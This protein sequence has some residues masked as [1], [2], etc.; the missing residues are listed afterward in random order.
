MRILKKLIIVGMCIVLSLSAL[1]GCSKKPSGNE[2][3]SRTVVDMKG[4]TVKLPGTIKSYCVLYSSAVPMCAMVD[5]NLEHM[6][7][8]P[9]SNYFEY[10]YGE[11]FKTVDN[12]AV[13]VDKKKVT[14][15][16]IIESGAQVVFWNRAAHEDLVASLE[17]VGIAC[18]NVQVKDSNDLI[19]AMHV[20]A[21]S[22]GT[23]YAQS[24]VEKYE[25]KYGN[26]LKQVNES[27]K[28]IPEDKKQSVLVI[29]SIDSPSVGP[30][31]SYQGYWTELTGL[32]Y[33]TPVGK[34]EPEAT[35]TME[36]IY[37]LDP[38][39]IIVQSPFKRSEILS[40]SQWSAL[41]AV[42]D[43]NI[44]SNPSV[45]DEWGMPTTEAP[46][47]FIWVLKYFYPDYAGKIDAEKELIDFYKDFYGYNMSEKDAKALLSCHHF[48]L[49]ESLKKLEE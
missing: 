36:K 38:D 29:G 26:Y 25:K 46:L 12:H 27:V 19:K 24:Q 9:I 42:K 23:K 5:K 18:V 14:A 41:R 34:G 49:K 21:D 47:Q 22:F 33:V 6:V 30:V 10:W 1:V 16:Q 39:I 45:L 3:E 17:A 32:K 13:Q 2:A 31:D 43:G 7:M 15:E 48:Y 20:I 35:L 44:Y 4:K 11:M 28:Q 40:D 37:D 8:Y